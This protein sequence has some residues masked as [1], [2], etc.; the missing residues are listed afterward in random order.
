MRQ[1]GPTIL[2]YFFN[3]LA[4]LVTG[5]SFCFSFRDGVIHRETV[6]NIPGLVLS[7]ELGVHD[8]FEMLIKKDLFLKK[9]KR[10][11]IF[12]KEQQRLIASAQALLCR[13]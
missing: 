6:M 9:L 5:H 10:F 8:V 12:H 2:N 7:G 1:R 11:T 3:F 4:L 13:P